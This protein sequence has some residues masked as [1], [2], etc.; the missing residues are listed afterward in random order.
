MKNMTHAP[1]FLLPDQDNVTHSLGEY[2]GRW[3]VL[4]FYPR[5]ET[6]GCTT[7]ACAFRDGRDALKEAGAEVL[8]VSDDSVDSHKKFADNHG[9]NF[10]LLSDEQAGTIKAYGAWDEV[11]KKSL[12]KT[13]IINPEG[14]IAK[15]YPTV[16]PEG[17]FE[18]VLQDLKFLK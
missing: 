1:D 12:R 14:E 4:Y 15:T 11:N 8:G 16:T 13:F 2:K 17:H 10:V 6:P 5:D 7:E 9:L 3:V 18:Q